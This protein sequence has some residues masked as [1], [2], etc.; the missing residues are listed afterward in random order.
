MKYFPGIEFFE[1]ES[2]EI[3]SM[4][5]ISRTTTFVPELARVAFLAALISFNIADFYI[6]ES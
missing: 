1:T 3:E 6:I 5:I 2:I 4:H